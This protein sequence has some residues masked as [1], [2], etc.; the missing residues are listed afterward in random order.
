[1]AGKISIN[2]IWGAE[3]LLKKIHFQFF[4]GPPRS[5]IVDPLAEF[6]LITSK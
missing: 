5:L 2:K 4:L 1:M 6:Q 3:T